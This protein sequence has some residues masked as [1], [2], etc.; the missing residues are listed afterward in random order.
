MESSRIGI[1][2][3]RRTAL[4]LGLI[5]VLAVIGAVLFVG[6]AENE[7]LYDRKYFERRAAGSASSAAR[8][9]PEVIRLTS[10]RSVID[11]GCGTGEWA[12]EFQKSGVTD[13]AGVDGDYIDRNMLKIAPQLFLARDLRNPL[14]LDRTFDLAL[15]LEVAEHLPPA[16]AE[17]FVADLTAL[18]PVVLFSAA[19]PHQNGTDHV[20][21]QW[22]GYWARMFAKHSYVA[23][24]CLRSRF[25]NDTRVQWWYCQNM[26]LYARSDRV[27]ASPVLKGILDQQPPAVLSLVHPVP[28]TTQTGFRQALGA[29]RRATA[30]AIQR[31]LARLF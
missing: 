7:N 29:L 11:L 14:S 31:R 28:Y 19:I 3:I 21:E 10:P 13:V 27:E 23:L 30:R 18:A 22:P 4:G 5:A 8:V 6:S 25:W 12:A 9:V 2:T 17:G 15:A 24:D 26:I 16:R 1:L 20:N